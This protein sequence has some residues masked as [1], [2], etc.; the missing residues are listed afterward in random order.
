MSEDKAGG[1]V[2]AGV[3]CPRVTLSVGT[4]QLEYQSGSWPTGKPPMEQLKYA[5]MRARQQHFQQMHQQ[6]Q[7]PRQPCPQAPSLSHRQVLLG[8]PLSTAWPWLQPLWPRLLRA[9]G[10]LTRAWGPRTAWA[11]R[12]NCGATAAATSW[13]PQPGGPVHQNTPLDPMVSDGFWNS[14]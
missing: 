10:P 4:G 1:K 9:V 13:S 2:C 6:Q 12:V 14:G 11:G 7:Q 3:S 8:H 5:E